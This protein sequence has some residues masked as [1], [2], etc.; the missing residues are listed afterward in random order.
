LVE[1]VQQRG[2]AMESHIGAGYL[3]SLSEA[4]N[5]F[6]Y[7]YE[8]APLLTVN[9]EH[10]NPIDRDDDFALLLAQMADMK[11]RREFFNRN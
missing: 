3:K 11:G 10:L 2:I 7:Y 9:T 1:R 6:F 8:A 5:R 4:Y